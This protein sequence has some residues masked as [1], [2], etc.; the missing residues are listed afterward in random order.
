MNCPK[1]GGVHFGSYE[2]PFISLPCV[3]CGDETV[4]ACSDCAIESGGK[5][6]VHVCNKSTCR[7]QHEAL[8]HSGFSDAVG[9]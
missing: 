6:S 3:I 2:C 4:L 5:I 9:G 1:C 8:A 7:D